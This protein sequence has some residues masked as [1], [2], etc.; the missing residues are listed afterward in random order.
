MSALDVTSSR[1]HLYSVCKDCVAK[2]TQETDALVLDLIEWV[3]AKPRPYA[4]VMDAWRTSCPRLT[5]WEDAVDQGYVS[6]ERQEAAG[7]IV[8]ATPLGLARLREAG[9]IREPA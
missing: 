5:I 3:A 8:K 9:R 2:V 7:S 4:E 1:R 6:C